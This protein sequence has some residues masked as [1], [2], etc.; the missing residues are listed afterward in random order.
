MAIDFSRFIVRNQDT[1]VNL[2]N[3]ISGAFQSLERRKTEERAT[4][5]RTDLQNLKTEA[6]QKDRQLKGRGLAFNQIGLISDPGQQRQQLAVMATEAQ[7]IG[8]DPTVFQTLLN[9]EDNDELSLA[10]TRQSQKDLIL[11]GGD[12]FAKEILKGEAGGGVDGVKTSGVTKILEDGTIISVRTDGS[13]KVTDP[14]GVVLTG[15]AAADAIKEANRLEIEERQKF[16]DIEVGKQQKVEET[17]LRLR[18]QS[19]VK[20]DIGDRNRDAARGLPKLTDALAAAE[21]ASQGLTGAA[22]L[23][24]SRFL[25]GIDVAD[26]AALDAALKGLALDQLQKF[27][28]PTT[29]FEFSVVQQIAGELGNSKI[30]NIARIKSLQRAN[31]FQREEFKQLQKFTGDPDEF[32]FD[33]QATKQFGN[34]IFTLQ[35]IQETA[36]DNGMSI[37]EVLAKLRKLGAQ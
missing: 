34:K 17:K 21:T 5:A 1:G 9:I 2:A 37:E 32:S 25:P 26:E 18:R 10:L 35:Q 8:Q 7:Q 11:G 23:T 33:F 31:W 20:K 30:A 24:L 19:E 36:V 15:K 6:E 4:Q 12:A 16:A 29:D 28:G 3:Q 27:K 13:R 14:E 22:K